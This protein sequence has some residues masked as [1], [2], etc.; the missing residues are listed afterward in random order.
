MRPTG[1]VDTLP[2]SWFVAPVET[3]ICILI[4]RRFVLQVYCS[5]WVITRSHGSESIV[6]TTSKVNGKCWTLNDPTTTHIPLKRSSPNLACVISGLTYVMDTFHQE[7]FGVNRLRG[8]V[9]PYARNNYS[10]HPHVC[11]ATL[12]SHMFRHFRAWPRP[13]TFLLLARYVPNVAKRSIDLWDQCKKKY[14]AYIEDRPTVL[15]PT[16]D[17]RLMT[18][19]L[20]KFKWR[21]LRGV[22]SD[23][24]YTPC[25]VLGWGFRG[26]RIE[27][28]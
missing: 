25:L 1:V 28:R 26:R 10:L 27:R 11:Y 13:T 5:I 6:R 22:S 14:R 8:F 7:I 12:R 24:A 18:S 20:G 4:T 9:S 16:T 15:R 17:D 3:K 2:L 23:L 19:H 21:Y